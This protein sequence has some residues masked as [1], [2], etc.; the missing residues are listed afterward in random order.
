MTALQKTLL[1]AILL[2]AP[3][4][5]AGS[6]Q[7]TTPDGV[8]IHCDT[9]GRGV[10]AVVL[11]HEE[12]RSAEDWSWYAEKLAAEGYRVVAVDVRGHGQS[13]PPAPPEDWTPASADV[14]AA[15]TW[16]KQ[17]GATELTVVG[18]GLGG[19]LGALAASDPGVT[20]LVLLSPGLNL[21]GVPLKPAVVAYG[22]R[23]LLLVAS[24]EDTYAAK[25][26]RFLDTVATG[27][28]EVKVVATG[29]GTRLIN[30]D[31]DL[32][33]LVTAWIGGAYKDSAGAAHAGRSV[34][35]GAAGDLETSGKRFGDD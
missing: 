21:G 13:N 6:L 8:G 4:A 27:P 17:R 9:Y 24:T 29:S 2:P 30:R 3:V 31:P 10:R 23:P 32:E 33:A 12:G 22:E 25:S 18:A 15:V 34:D 19:T 20:N 1:L 7:L 16:L 14:A 5:V 28:H 11:V 35:V 26:A